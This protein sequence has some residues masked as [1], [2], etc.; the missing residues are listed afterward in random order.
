ME[1]NENI[2]SGR[3]Y[4]LFLKW[5]LS[6]NWS[7]YLDLLINLL[8]VALFATITTA[9]IRWLV[10]FF[11]R[12]T[13]KLKRLS[14]L[15]YLTKNKFPLYLS[16]FI[17]YILVKNFIPIIFK[18]FS[19][20]I[21]PL[22]KLADIWAVLIFI[23]II[24]S[25]VKTG[26]DILSHKPS[27]QDKPI[28]SYQQVVMTVLVIFG[29]VVCYSIITGKSVGY[30]FTAIAAGSAVIM[31]IFQ[32]SIKG[33][34]ASV[35]VTT[36]DMIHI[37]DWITMP[38]YGAD[39]D[40]LEVNLTTV[41]V[42][43]FDKT[44]TTIPTY[45][46]VSDSFQ[47][48]RG[49]EKAGGRRIKRAIMLKQNSIRYISDDE[50][51]RFKKIQGIADYIDARQKEIQEHNTRIGADRSLAVN[52]RNLTNGGL[53]RQYIEW[54]LHNHPDTH[55]GFTMMVRQLAP[56]PTGMPLE[57]Y[58]FT[59]TTKWIAYENIMSDIF[60]HLIAA[61]EYFDLEIFEI[62]A[63]TDVRKVDLK[64]TTGFN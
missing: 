19:T 55:K 10:N 7:A 6:E 59:N 53:F 20:W 48:W 24:M 58:A 36:N 11:I 57:I 2:F 56:T 30:F 49:M 15:N 25:L 13:T 47:N 51:P 63:S 43:N 50:L 8:I 31:L 21:I 9:L 29:I 27:F 23:Q 34:V 62:E 52:G 37:G 46:L 4:D 22:D 16:L 1:I 18:N 44:I 38:K 35:L 41:K 54:Y 17:P 14:W 64:Q 28:K 33:F 39:G 32:D 40:V 26:F 45:A 3:L 12:K 5:G 61:V 60:D 42:Q